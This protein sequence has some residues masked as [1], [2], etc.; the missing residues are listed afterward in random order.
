M[1]DRPTSD[2]E[3]VVLDVLDDAWAQMVGRLDGL[4]DAEYLWEPVD[5]CW[6]VR[7]REDGSVTVDGEGERDRDPPP[8]TTIAWRLWHIGVDCLDAYSE[9]LLGRTGASVSGDA[10]HLEA[11]AA[12]EDLERSWRCFRGGLGDLA[13]EQWWE[14]LGDDWG[15]WSRHSVLDLAVHALHEIAHHGAE[16]AL[17][18]D[19]YREGL[20]AG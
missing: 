8:V 11:A 5:G 14:Q 13:A 20:A 3:V 12:V 15:P 1:S 17:L 18:R 6:T 2:F 16:V 7:A 19:L 4:S 10:W 9:R